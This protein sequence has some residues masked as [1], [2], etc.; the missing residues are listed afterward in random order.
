MMVHFFGKAILNEL[1]CKFDI[2]ES[3]V[4]LL[5]I[6]IL[7]SIDFIFQ[8]TEKRSSYYTFYLAKA[9]GWRFQHLMLLNFCYLTSVTWHGIT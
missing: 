4:S 1:V 7:I 2:V 3:N 6:Y 5:W 9:Q 8:F